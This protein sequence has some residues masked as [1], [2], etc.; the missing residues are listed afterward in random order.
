MKIIKA[1]RINTSRHFGR[2]YRGFA[3]RSTDSGH[4]RKDKERVIQVDSPGWFTFLDA[5]RSR[6]ERSHDLTL[7]VGINGSLILRRGENTIQIWEQEVETHGQDNHYW[8]QLRGPGLDRQAS[9]RLT[10]E[11]FNTML[12]EL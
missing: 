7:E 10:P 2:Q 5:L 1:V 6:V 11:T 4:L 3:V 8:V 9:Q 12:G